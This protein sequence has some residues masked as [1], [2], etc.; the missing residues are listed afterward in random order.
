MSVFKKTISNAFYMILVWGVLTTTS[1][2]FQ[3]ISI[4]YLTQEEFGK[5]LTAINFSVFM[6]SIIIL[7]FN[8]AIAKL[9]PEYKQR[10][11]YNKIKHII[12]KSFII[13]LISN[14]IVSSIILL[15]YKPVS[16]LI[17]LP[18]PVLIISVASMFFYS[19]SIFFGNVVYGLQNMKKYFIAGSFFGIS[20]LVI[21]LTLIIFGF[22]FF[23]PIIGFLIGSIIWFLL[24][25]EP[26]M[27]TLKINGYNK[28][29][30]EYS[31]PGLLSTFSNSLFTNAQYVI[32]TI[33]RT[34]KL[35]GIF[36]VGMLISSVI[37]VIPNILSLSIFPILSELSV[38][39]KKEQIHRLIKYTFKYSLFFTVPIIFIFSIFGENLIL[40]FA[41]ESY[42]NAKYIIPILS[43][44]SLVMSLASS[45]NNAIYASKRPTIYKY[46]LLVTSSIFLLI[47]PVLSYLKGDIGISIGFFISMLV[48]FIL[49][50]V[51]LKKIIKIKFPIS[52]VIKILFTSILIF[53]PIAF[54]KHY[55]SNTISLIVISFISFISYTLFLVFF[56]FYNEDD[57]RV[58]KSF[59]DKMKLSKFNFLI[60]KL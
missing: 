37:G 10:K 40:L 23:G 34:V 59:L 9:I 6:S 5:S 14:F 50:F 35:T 4:K 2:I 22:N 38:N 47:T 12:S 46:I 36:G 7:G 18:I 19:L 45:L 3:F 42:I 1:F 41:N 43:I 13:I 48:F 54:F 15:N 20:K 28:E 11:K 55:I 60:D 25:F 26:K 21:S 17:K 49:S 27:I 31:V 8:I 58:I 30:F 32:L 51:S 24:L 29:L 57:K 16:L 33:V 52:D 39:G 53:S 44:S 56:K